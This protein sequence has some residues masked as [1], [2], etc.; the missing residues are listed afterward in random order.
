[1]RAQRAVGDAAA[2]RAA[3]PA[4]RPSCPD[5]AA[6][7][8]PAL[9]RRCGRCWRC[10]SAS[11]PRRAA[12]CSC[13]GETGV[14][15]GGARPAL[16]ALGAGEDAPFVH[17]NCAALPET[18]VESELFG[19]EKGAF[20]DAQ[21]RPGADWWRWPAAARSSS[22]RW[23]SCRWRCRPSCSP[24]STRARFRRLGGSSEQT[25]HRAGGGG[26]QPESR[27]G[28]RARAA[29]ARTSGSG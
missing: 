28:D 16:H 7:S 27:G 22:T 5:G 18:T 20:T 10:W 3:E 9:A 6:W 25:Q 26:H 2:P 24:S 23:A 29:S 13:S 11:P 8:P 17:V 4:S 15:Q 1:M 14:G 19:H 12:R 21:A